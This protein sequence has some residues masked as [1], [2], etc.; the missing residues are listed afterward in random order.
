MARQLQ[1]LEAAAGFSAL[2]AQGGVELISEADMENI[3]A[4][5]VERIILTRFLKNG[6][7]A[8]NSIEEGI[9]VFSGEAAVTDY[10]AVND[11]DNA[12]AGWMWKGFHGFDVADTRTSAM[13]QPAM[14]DL[15]VR[16]KMTTGQVLQ[17][18]CDDASG[19]YDLIRLKARILIRL[20]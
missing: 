4:C 1:W 6:S 2:A 13:N 7:T 5:T 11:V 17:Y 15:R 18:L 16:R 19:D 12:N 3:R 10:P 9:G 20:A 8:Q 14:V